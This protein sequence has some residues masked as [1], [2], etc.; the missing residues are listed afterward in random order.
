M[1]ENLVLRQQLAVLSRSSRR[2]RLQPADRLFWSWLSRYWKP[3]RS[4]LVLVQPDTVIRW[5]RSAWRRYWTWNSR[6]RGGRPRLA[7]E[8][9][10]LIQRLARENPRWGSVRIR[11]E[12]RK[13]GFEVSA[14][15]VRCYRRSALRRPPSQT[16]RT[17][18]RNHAPHIWAADFF[19]VP[20]V[21]FCTL[22]IFFFITHE[23]RWLAHLNVITH[24]I[25]EWVWRQLV[26]AM[27][28]GQQPRYL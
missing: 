24:P 3:W 15:S 22:Y 10:A 21:T 2:A 9:R 26:A 4:V 20:T 13:L 18:L 27:P 23:R 1:L 12:L 25:A 5:H 14:E 19:T 7:P 6:H 17:F 8:L 28:W 16:W 11:G